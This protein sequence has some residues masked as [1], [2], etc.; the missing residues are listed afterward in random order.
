MYAQSTSRFAT[1]SRCLLLF[2][3]T[4]APA[5]AA[6]T[7][8]FADI[9]GWWSAEPT[10]RDAG[11]TEST[12]RL[13]YRDV[14]NADLVGNTDRPTHAGES[15]RVLLHFLEENGK[16]SVR[17]SLLGI[18]GYD[19]PI[20]TVAISGDTLEMQPYPFPL[21]Y[22]AANGTLSGH[23][24]EAAVPVYKIPV[25]FR[26]SEPLAKPAAP[27]WNAPRPAVKWTFDAKAPVW[28]GLAHDATTGLL[29]VGNEQGALHAIDLSGKA[30]WTFETGKAI[31]A[32]PAVIGDAV[33]VSSDS[34]LLY[35]L[36]KRTGQERWRA[37][38]DA[39]SPERIPTNDPKTRWDRYGSSVVADAAAV[40]VA[41]RD[42]HLYA[43]DLASGK[44][45][46]R[47]A[48]QDLMTA[49]PALYRNLVLFAAFDGAVQAVSA[50]DGK[51]QWTYDAKLAVPGDLVVHDDRVFVGSRTYDLIALDARSGRELWKHYYW[52]S[53]IES[54]P[55]VR[56]GVVYTGSSDATAVYA[57][58]A[59]D[60]SRKWRTHV[61]GWPW[62]RTAVDDKLVVAA[63][64][65]QGKYPGVRAGSL[66]GIDRASGAIRW[67]YLDPPAQDVIDK[68]LEWGFGASPLLIDGVV[69]AADLSGRVLAIESTP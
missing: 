61:P 62:A 45:R 3:M 42:E 18:G 52:F 5:Q 68:K 53:W 16:Q 8:K 69:Y 59:A 25:V 1:L 11:R 23:L 49:T 63:T 35:K 34:G 38:I 29:Y 12:D 48:A 60:G 28:A 13:T 14:G 32:R 2:A 33:Y 4:A 54:P 50:R 22:D 19:V 30:R 6:D 39:G 64:V 58:S 66:A 17:L 41:S 56:D 20:G 26:R 27:E 44:Q 21:K 57:V 15:S 40:Y 37:K 46:W 55:V 24:P 43:L 10:Y 51:T 7:F 67:I 9:A 31:K 36:D 47:A 65:G